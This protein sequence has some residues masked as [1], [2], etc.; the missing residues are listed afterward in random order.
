M[1][2]NNRT[3]AL[4]DSV[5]F[6]ND[7]I[8]YQYALHLCVCYVSNWSHF[9][10]AVFFCDTGNCIFNA[11]TYACTQSIFFYLFACLSVFVFELQST[12]FIL[13]VLWIRI[14]QIFPFDVN[15]NA[16]AHAHVYAFLLFASLQYSF[17]YR[18]NCHLPTHQIQ[19]KQTNKQNEYKQKLANGRQRARAIIVSFNLIHCHNK[20][21]HNTKLLLFSV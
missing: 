9:E 5:N 21:A 17:I 13:L 7:Y 16:C 18:F 11:I 20:R 4:N 2:T 8:S 19:N 15:V 6:W 14:E 1:R 12:L 3:H 10:Y